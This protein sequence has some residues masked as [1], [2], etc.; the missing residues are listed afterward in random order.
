MKSNV[1][2]T[3]YDL[4]GVEHR[5]MVPIGTNL[6]HALIEKGLSPYTSLTENF[7]CG[8][9]GLCATCGIW[10]EAYA[11][12][13]QHWHDRLAN[14]YRY[15]RLSCQITVESEMTVRLVKK[16]IWGGRKKKETK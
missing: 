9:N 2:I 4:H 3:I 10:I 6:R 8:G 13:P 11:P 5:T 1:R 14:K 7:N 12:T 15:P 16:R